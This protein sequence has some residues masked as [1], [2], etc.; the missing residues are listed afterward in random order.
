VSFAHW[1]GIT[2]A[3]TAELPGW[4]MLSPEEQAALPGSRAVM[5]EGWTD[6][7]RDATRATLSRLQ[8]ALNSFS[9]QG[10]QLAVGTD[11]HPGG[12]FFHLELD[13]YRQAG[14]SNA[15]VLQAAT[16]GGARALRREEDLGSL[17][18]GKLADLIVV[19]GDPRTD[20]TALQRVRHAIVGGRIVE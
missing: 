1:A 9:E 10:G 3:A 11:A 7:E 4:S 6:A 13:F 18:A 20:L 16:A 5:S 8:S 19:D 15:K 17:E 12:L 14:L 2:D